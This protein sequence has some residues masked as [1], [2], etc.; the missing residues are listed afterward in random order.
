M[1]L[2]KSWWKNRTDSSAYRNLLHMQFFR[3][4]TVKSFQIFIFPQHAYSLH[5]FSS[6]K[7]S[8]FLNIRTKYLVMICY[9]Q[10]VI[11]AP[12]CNKS[13]RIGNNCADLWQPLPRFGTTKAAQS[14]NKSA[15]ISYIF[16]NKKLT[17]PNFCWFE[18]IVGIAVFERKNYNMEQL[19]DKHLFQ[20]STFHWMFGTFDCCFHIGKAYCL[21]ERI[22]FAGQKD[23]YRG[24]FEKRIFF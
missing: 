16:S 11:A 17:W 20:Q 10:F 8:F 15:P 24:A 13:V 4:W 18:I 7:L 5:E 22:S 6:N 9:A 14:C 2:V 12:I 19:F 23:I 21:K 1:D 3:A